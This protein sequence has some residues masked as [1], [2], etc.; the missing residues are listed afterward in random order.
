MGMF[1][2]TFRT[3]SRELLLIALAAL[4]WVPFYFLV[5]VS[6]KP[7][8][9]LVT[10]PF[11][12]PHH[13]AFGNYSAAWSGVAGVTLG[14]ALI[15]SLIITV[16]SVIALIVIGSACAY[17][18]ARREGRLGTGLYLLF[19]IGIIIPFQLGVIPV[20]SA[21]RATGLTGTYPGMILLYTGLMMPLA[22]FLYTG[23]ARAMPRDYEEA[24][25]MDGASRLRTFARVVFPL[26]RP[27]TA[28]VAVLTSVIIWNDFFGQL[29]FLAGSPRQ[30]LPVI[31][32]SFV[33]Q[34]ASQWNLIFAAVVV[35]LAPVLAFYLFAQRQLIRGFSGGIKT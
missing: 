5:I 34:Y 8:S 3:F 14:S 28:T 17:A 22:V 2:Y 20:Y 12:F 6:L 33:G 15:N 23:F 13:L 1:R 24:A 4:W 25:Y 9:E 27:A 30:T 11:G 26:L 18:I 7:S 21:L 19:L 32:Y 16:G 35:S 29:I 10:D 31:I